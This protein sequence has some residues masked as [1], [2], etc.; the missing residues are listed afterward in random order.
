MAVNKNFVVKNGLEVGGGLIYADYDNSLVGVGTTV[1]SYDFQVIG[2]IGATDLKVTGFSTTRSLTVTSEAYLSTVSATGIAATNLSVSGVGTFAKSITTGV[3]TAG[4]LSVGTAGTT[5]T[6]LTGGKVGIGTNNAIQRFQVGSANETG[7]T[8]TTSG[9]FVVT[10]D[11]KVGVQTGQ[12]EVDFHVFGDQTVTGVITATTFNGQVNSGVSTIVNLDVTNANVSIST[13]TYISGINLNYSGISTLGNVI[14]GSGITDLIVNGDARVTGILTIGSSSITLNG[15]NNTVTIGTG[16]T[17]SGNGNATA[18]IITASR[19]IGRLEGNAIT[20]DSIGVANGFVNVGIIT[21]LSGSNLNYTGINTI[22]T[23]NSTNLT[24]SSISGTAGTITTFDGTNGTITNLTSSS[25][26]GTAGTITTFNGTNGTITNLSGTAGTITTLNSTNG[27]ITNLS[28]SNLNYSGIGTIGAIKIQNKEIVATSGIAT[29]YGDGS[30]L[31]GVTYGVGIRSDGSTIAGAG[32]T[33]INFTG[34][35][36]STVTA[37]AGI[38][39][40]FVEG[41]AATVPTQIVL[42]NDTTSASTHYLTFSAGTSGAQQLK[43]DSSTLTYVPNTNTITANLSGTASNATSATSATNATNTAITND[44]TSGST[45][46]ITFVAGTSGNQGQKVDSTGLTYLPSTN[47]LSGNIS[48]NA[49]TVTT[50]PNLT[51]DI[52]SSGTATAIAT[53]VIV[54]ADISGSAAIAVSKL[55]AS[56]ISGVTLGGSLATL[57]RGT[58][59]TGS[60]YN[61]SAGQTWAVDATSANTASKVV[62]RDASGNFAGNTITCVTLNST[63]DINLKND[64]RPFENA[65]TTINQLNGVHFTW[66]QDDK[67]SI[68]VIAQEIEAVLPEL[69]TETE[70][71]KTV[72]Y[73]GLIGVLI[74]A[75]KELSAKVEKL[76]NKGI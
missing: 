33:V 44:T 55:A 7:F 47:T 26:S 20:G 49:A 53:G 75:V 69:V 18:G 40:I 52:T 42:T 28:G 63:S 56:T 39:T 64:V 50:I 73:N 32:V 61:G 3:S 5:I 57:T 41:G 10:Y 76:E 21:Y 51:G 66:K 8:T 58:Y 12:P 14:V 45:H 36:I 6:T 17:L 22:R 34:S 54:N 35:G 72:N 23:L 9:L 31:A 4:N 24:S 25:I 71:T 59:L 2:G 15:N 27:T 37:N 43:V 67:K 62:A 60:N 30:K 29:F 70:G 13:V 11:G 16:I 48:G 38:A 74:E 19:F 65:L 46:Y 1:I 68:G